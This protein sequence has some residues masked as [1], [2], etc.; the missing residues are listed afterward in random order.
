[1]P[2]TSL[3]AARGHHRGAARDPVSG[4]HA[5][6]FVERGTRAPGAAGN[7]SVSGVHAPD[8]VERLESLWPPQCP[9]TLSLGFMPQTSLSEA[10]GILR[11]SG[12]Y[13]VSG[14]HA[15]DFVERAEAR[16]WC[17]PEQ[18]LSL[19]FM[20]Q[21]SLSAPPAG[22]RQRL[23]HPVSGVHAPDFVERAVSGQGASQ[24]PSC[25]WGSCPR[26]R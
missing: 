18:V 11:R 4:V 22:R 1:M 9:K 10:V 3:S 8:F 24:R 20:P 21:T 12:L 16:I 2:Q 13:A 23:D 17:G 26:L 25:L 6:D 19:G 14:V 7:A 15:P 5:P